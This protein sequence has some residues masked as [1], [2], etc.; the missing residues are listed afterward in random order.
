MLI[1]MVVVVI[2]VMVANVMVVPVVMVIVIPPAS[3]DRHEQR[4]SNQS[5]HGCTDNLFPLHPTAP[6]DLTNR[7]AHFPHSVV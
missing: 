5:R 4:Q 3:R 7:L 6:F 2:V 1:M